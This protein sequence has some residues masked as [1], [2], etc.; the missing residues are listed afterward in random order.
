M[1]SVKRARRVEPDQRVRL[2]QSVKR[3]RRAEPDLQAQPVSLDRLAKPGL[4]V[5]QEPQEAS[6]IP[7]RLASP[8]PLVDRGRTDYHLQGQ[9]APCKIWTRFS[10]ASFP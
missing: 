5:N 6:A 10:E 7:D 3:D 4:R 2:V 9:L 8:G 1:Q